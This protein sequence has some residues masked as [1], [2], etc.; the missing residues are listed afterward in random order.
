[1]K[2]FLYHLI[3]FQAFSCFSH[4]KSVKLARML[5]LR[6]TCMKFNST[7]S[8]YFVFL[9]NFPPFLYFVFKQT[10][11]LWN[12]LHSAKLSMTLE[13]SQSLRPET[14]DRIYNIVSSALYSTLIFYLVYQNFCV[15]VWILSPME[16]R[17][18]PL[19]FNIF[20]HRSKCRKFLKFFRWS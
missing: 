20:Q 2:N 18:F 3:I 8:K 15:D 14:F 6:K 4:K 11:M 7:L 5:Y 19:I 9:E 12:C 17:V 16:F 1:M 10:L 13:N